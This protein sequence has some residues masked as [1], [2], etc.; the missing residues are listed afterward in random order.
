ME[1]SQEVNELFS[2]VET[3]PSLLVTKLLHKYENAELFRFYGET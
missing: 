1:S 2:M 3:Q